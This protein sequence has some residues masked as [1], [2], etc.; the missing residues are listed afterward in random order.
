MVRP[1]GPELRYLQQH[2]A[3]VTTAEI[4]LCPPASQQSQLTH[5]GLGS[6]VGEVSRNLKCNQMCGNTM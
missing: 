1:N 6:K 5:H 4:Q 2:I 3:T